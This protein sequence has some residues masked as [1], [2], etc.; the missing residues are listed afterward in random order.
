MAVGKA[1]EKAA[2]RDRLAI[3]FAR[4]PRRPSKGLRDPAYD[5][6]PCLRR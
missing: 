2:D 5:E 4:H 6:A 3:W 1:G